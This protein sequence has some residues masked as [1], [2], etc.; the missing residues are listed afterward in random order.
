M[1]CLKL[2]LQHSPK[3]DEPSLASAHYRLGMLYEKK[4]SRDLARREYS[5]ALELDASRRDA[6]EALKK[7]S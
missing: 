2:Y 3:P 1:E 7:I 4:G 6:R 5:A